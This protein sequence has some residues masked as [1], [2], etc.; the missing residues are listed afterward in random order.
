MIYIDDIPTPLQ[1]IVENE[2]KKYKGEIFDMIRSSYSKFRSLPERKW[3]VQFKWREG[4]MKPYKT[5]GK[6]NI[7]EVR[8]GKKGIFITMTEDVATKEGNR[9]VTIASNQQK[10]Q[11]GNIKYSPRGKWFRGTMYLNKRDMETLV[12][13]DAFSGAVGEN[14]RIVMDQPEIAAERLAKKREREGLLQYYLY[15]PGSPLVQNRIKMQSIAQAW[16]IPDTDEMDRNQLANAIYSKIEQGEKNKDKNRNL[17]AFTKA[18]NAFGEDFRNLQ[19]IQMSKDRGLLRFSEMDKLWYAYNGELE[20]EKEMYQVAPKDK[21]IADQLLASH[22]LSNKR[23]YDHIVMNLFAHMKDKEGVDIQKEM[24]PD[25]FKRL[26]GETVVENKPED[27]GEQQTFTKP[28][29]EKDEKKKALLEPDEIVELS[30]NDLRKYAMNV[31]DMKLK[32]GLSKKDVATECITISQK[33]A[34]L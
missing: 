17:D 20:P 16:G 7:K 14:K 11:S 4:I 30:W 32:P 26:F 24:L 31:C 1:S 15:T 18:I 10:D 25:D 34:E 29:S 5:G 28:E 13:F 21:N 33:Y 22:M 2:D 3:P 12:F 27:Q 9:R 6:T 8:Q 23:K 19:Y